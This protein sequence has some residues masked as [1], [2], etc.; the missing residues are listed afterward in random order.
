MLVRVRCCCCCG[1]DGG[2]GGGTRGGCVC[3]CV[4]GLNFFSTTVCRSITIYKL[5][6][7]FFGGRGSKLT[8]K[9]MTPHRFNS[10]ITFHA[11]PAA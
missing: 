2:G 3:V 5:G 1:V 11:E 8:S 10:N 7:P 4:G 9:G 6:K